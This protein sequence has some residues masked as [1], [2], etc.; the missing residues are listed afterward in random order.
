MNIVSII[1][2]FNYETTSFNKT[3]S[4]HKKNFK[5]IIIVNNRKNVSLKM[6]E[7][8]NIIII[9]N[10]ENVGLA[11]ALNIGIIHAKKMNFDFVALF[12]QDTILPE[13]FNKEMCKKITNHANKNKVAV[14]SPVYFNKITNQ[15]G[16]L[17]NFKFLR[18]LRDKPS[19]GEGQ[20]FSQYV[21]TSGS[22]IPLKVIDDVGLMD[23]ELFIDFID[24]EWCLRAKRKGYLISSFQNIIVEH[25]LGDSKVRLLGTNFPIHSPLRMY[26]FFRNSIYLYSNKEIDLNWRVVDAT[27]SIFRFVFYML[28]VSNRITY[29]KYILKGLH[30]GFIKKMGKLK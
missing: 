22:Y 15:Y 27:R 17:I 1:I 24:I 9:N 12:D 7:G 14:F 8:K 29:L 3:F 25:F 20:F 11:K 4:A 21:I 6:F 2:F 5:N 30:H 16:S 18:L 28:F 26:Y 13:G 23:E 10:E 19:K